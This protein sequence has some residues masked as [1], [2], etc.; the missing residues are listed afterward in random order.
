MK[1]KKKLSQIKFENK[2]IFLKILYG[3][4]KIKSKEFLKSKKIKMKG[5]N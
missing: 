5:E 2:Y 3:T 4:I 1:L